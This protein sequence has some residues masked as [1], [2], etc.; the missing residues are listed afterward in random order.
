MGG[1]ASTG[2]RTSRKSRTTR[3]SRPWVPAS[4]VSRHPQKGIK[5]LKVVFF[6]CKL[7]QVSVE[8]GMPRPKGKRVPV[9]LSVSMGA[10]V[11]AKLLQLTDKQDVSLAWMIRKALAEF[12]ERQEQEDQAE[13]PLRRSGEEGRTGSE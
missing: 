6:W 5:V 12:I 11:H 9:R 1:I 4:D 10:D 2:S 8:S 7:M 13:L 3:Q